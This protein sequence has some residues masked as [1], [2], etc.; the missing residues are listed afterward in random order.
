M[1]IRNLRTTMVSVPLRQPVSFATRTVRKRDY[2][3]VEVETDEGITG[4]GLTW[5]HHP[6]VI[7]REYLQQ[8]VVG[9]DPFCIEKIWDRMYREI[10]RE[11]KGAAICALSAI[12]L[13]LWDILGK[14][15][16]QPVYRLLGGFR[17]QVPCYASGGY[18]R[19]GKGVSDLAKEMSNFVGRGFRAVKMKV[20]GVGLEKDVER[21]KAVRN[22]IGQD[23]ELMVDANNAYSVKQALLAG[24]QYEKYRVAWLEEPVWP[25][26]VKGSALVAQALDMPIAAGE[27]EY[28][29][30]GFRDL[31][32][33]AAADILQPDVMFCGGFS[34]ALKIAHLAGAWHLPISP[35]AAHDFSVHYVAAVAN[36]LSVEYFLRET[37]A[38]K[39]MELFEETLEPKNGFLELPGKPGLG[40]ELSVKA[41]RKYRVK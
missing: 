23:V 1:K 32:H 5:W 37:D 27:L 7:I 36:G 20:G 39:E 6:A 26:N 21:V 12:D 17:D 9:E 14:K 3:V 19:E 35:H 22:A 11:R 33:S 13:A 24:R 2:T 4:L 10:Y 30:Y 29:R 8:H 28:T 40:V 15:L 38:M 18:Y 16:G 41:L 34:E 31:V 25:D